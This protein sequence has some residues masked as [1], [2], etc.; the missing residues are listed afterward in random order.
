M[1]KL[2]CP[3]CRRENEPERIYCHD[4]GARLDR[5]VLAKAP[6]KTEDP[7]ATQ[8]RV[9]SMFDP[10]RALMKKRFFDTS[11]MILG[12]LLAAALIQMIRPPDLPEKPREAM[13][14]V[15]I[16]LDLENASMTPGSPQLR[17]TD[18]Q[19]NQYLGYSLKS[20]QTVLSKYL[21]FER[22]VV[23]FE[24][25]LCRLTVERSLFGFPIYTSTF[26]NAAIQNDT[27]VIKNRGGAIGRMPVHPMLMQYGDFLFSDL[28]AVVER[29]R[30]SVAKLAAVNIEPKLIVLTGR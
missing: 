14:P 26:F 27:L 12:A 20:K 17:Y 6:Q 22:A 16:S 19:V 25:D 23:A 28:A 5:S 9:K 29:E 1:I 3:E 30:K 10:G 15:Q 4:C 21:N 18:E 8:K 11:K 24:Q 13:L 7:N 2:V